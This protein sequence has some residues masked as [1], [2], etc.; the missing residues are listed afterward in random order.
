[1]LVDQKPIFRRALHLDVQDREDFLQ[2]QNQKVYQLRL[3]LQS[4]PLQRSNP[5]KDKQDLPLLIR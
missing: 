4:S 3:V 2:K 1:M 5:Q